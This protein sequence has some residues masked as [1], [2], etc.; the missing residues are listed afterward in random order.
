MFREAIIDLIYM[1]RLAYHDLNNQIH[2]TKELLGGCPVVSKI[3][4]AGVNGV[5]SYDTHYI[6]R[7]LNSMI[8]TFFH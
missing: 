2:K 6:Q 8:Q 4:L 7:F 1:L 5:I 3:D